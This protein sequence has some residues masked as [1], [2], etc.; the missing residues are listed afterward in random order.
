MKKALLIAYHFPP[1]RES[2]GIQRTLSLT[3]YLN[4]H[5]WQ[6][7]VLTVAS[8]AYIETDEG[9][10]KDIPDNIVV[11]R[12]MAWDASKHFSIAGRYLRCLA[13]PDRWASWVFAGVVSGLAMIRKNKPDVIW[14]TY[15]IATAHFIGL[16][17]HRLT[18]VPWVADCRDPMIQ[19][20]SPS[21]AA[22]RCIYRWVEGQVVKHASRVIFTTKGTRQVY[23]ERYPEVNHSHF[24]VIP[25]GYDEGFFSAVEKQLV[26]K[27]APNAK[28]T[29]V[30]S[31]ILYHSERDPTVFFE[32]LSELK[33]SR[34]ISADNVHIILRATGFA[35]IFQPMLDELLINDLVSLEP[36][37]GYMQALKE[38]LS[39]DGLLLFQGSN[40]NQQIPAKLYEYFR[41]AKPIFAL[42]DKVGNTAETIREAGVNN[43]VDLTNKEEIKK[44]IVDFIGQLKAGVA[45]V[46][47]PEV[48]SG[49]SRRALTAKFAKAFDNAISSPKT[50]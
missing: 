41:A 47:D 3:R 42:T 1:I 10:L 38:M 12:A 31:G 6:P 7:F 34:I 36:G 23:I 32:A 21:D 29:L 18:G 43:I 9:Q 28:I 5:G 45:Q 37:F 33:Q 40:C 35:K 2:S 39:A 48:T 44:G 27:Q 46:A 11:K 13:L 4:E 49:Y 50:N 24:V 30:H 20:D 8:K 17:L 14:S 22:Q 25:N 19:G 16:I 26:N 15:P